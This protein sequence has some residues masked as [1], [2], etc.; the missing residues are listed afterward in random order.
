MMYS[1]CTAGS[2]TTT[3][4]I[5]IL[6][7]R[8]FLLLERPEPLQNKTSRHLSPPG[9]EQDPTWIGSCSQT[10]RINLTTN[11]ERDA[12]RIRNN[13]ATISSLFRMNRNKFPTELEPRPA[14]GLHTDHRTAIASS[15]CRNQAP[16]SPEW[17]DLSPMW[18]KFTT[19]MEHHPC[20]IANQ[21]GRS[22]LRFPTKSE[23]NSRSSQQLWNIMLQVPN[24]Y[25]RSLHKIT[26]FMECYLH[27]IRNSL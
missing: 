18:G 15:L 8:L 22:P 24:N 20:R 1:H 9:T 12:Q 19:I 26:T 11:S 27:P 2:R 10:N 17:R 7:N 16:G 3:F 4:I 21:I 25:G 13:S 6:N 5:L 23:P 14:S